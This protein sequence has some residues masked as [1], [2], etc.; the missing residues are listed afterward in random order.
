[1][2]NN[3]FCKRLIKI[4]Q[5]GLSWLKTTVDLLKNLNWP[6]PQTIKIIANSPSND[7]EFYQSFLAIS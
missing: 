7:L 6:N 2:N 1:M 5:T 4:A 3:R